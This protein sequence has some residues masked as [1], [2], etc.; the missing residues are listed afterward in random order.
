MERKI[1]QHFNAFLMQKDTFGQ[2]VKD[3]KKGCIVGNK[4]HRKSNIFSMRCNTSK[5]TIA[6]KFMKGNGIHVITI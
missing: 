4:I 5:N 1:F 3:S 2:L 6:F